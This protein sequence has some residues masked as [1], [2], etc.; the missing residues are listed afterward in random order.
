M[1]TEIKFYSRE[2]QIMRQSQSKLALE[3]VA[4]L[5]VKITFKEL[6]RITDLFVECCLRPMDS[7]LKDRIEKM[8]KW[9]IKM[10]MT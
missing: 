4:S 3:Y 9:F 6:Q 7:D 8:D 2:I 5:G 1:S 10:I